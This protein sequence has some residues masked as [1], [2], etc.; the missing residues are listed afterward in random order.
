[1]Y[2]VKLEKFEGPLNLLLELIEE[3]KFDI[4][5]VSI[6]RVAD[7]YLEY[8]RGEDNISLENLADFV[9]IASKIIL[10]KS[11]SILPSLEVSEDEEKEI[12]D[13]EEQLR[14]YKKYKEAAQRINSIFS[15]NPKMHAREFLSGISAVFIPPKNFNAYDLKKYYLALID[16]IVLPE[17]IRQEAVQGI[18]TLEEKIEELQKN[19][20][21][22][23]EMSFSDIQDSAANKIEIIVS[24]LALL[25]L[26]KQKIIHVEQGELFTDI[27][28]KSETQIQNGNA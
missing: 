27:R 23:I 22:K 4:S 14:L 15:E 8:V 19:L 28:I 7:D 10:I 6:A 2:K 12:K 16:Q 21:E 26:V 18:V 17:K 5:E 9:N 24:F 13:L 1:V 25:E 11:R 20:R 3:Q